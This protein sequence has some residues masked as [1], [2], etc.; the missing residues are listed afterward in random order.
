MREPEGRVGPSA[1]FARSADPT[2]TDADRANNARSR[3][4]KRSLVARSVRQGN[5]SS[6][7]HGVYAEQ[8]VRPEVLDEAAVLMAR[9]D[10]LDERRDGV[11]I[12]ATARIIVRLR[13]LDAVIDGNPTTELTSLYA[14]LEGQ[15][16]RNVGLLGLIPPDRKFDADS[17]KARVVTAS[18]AQY[19]TVPEEPL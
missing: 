19:R 3:S 5:T 9:A 15:L 7:V 8:S 6:L 1:K 10:H 14:R 18:L 12:E 13:R 2:G 16:A 17:R 11:L 4:I